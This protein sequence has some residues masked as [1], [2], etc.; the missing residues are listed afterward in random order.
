VS[1]QPGDLKVVLSGDHY[2]GAPKAE[3]SVD[4]Q[5]VGTF[6]VTA[7]HKKGECRT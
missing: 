5:V 3:I 7:D 6:E 2:L 4:G 1:F